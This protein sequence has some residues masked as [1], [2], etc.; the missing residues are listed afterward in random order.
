MHEVPDKIV[1]KKV[2]LTHTLP[3]AFDDFGVKFLYQMPV[4][5]PEGVRLNLPPPPPIFKYPM[6]MLFS[7]EK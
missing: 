4:A 5:D 7:W 6:K 1:K 3:P 2:A